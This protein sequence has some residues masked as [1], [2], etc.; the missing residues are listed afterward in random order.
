M[1]TSGTYNNGQ[2]ISEQKG[3]VLT[4]YHKDGKIKARGKYVDGLMQGKWIFNKKEGYLWN[5]GHFKDSKKHGKWIRY[6][7]DGSVEKEEMFEEGKR[8]K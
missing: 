7:S 6:K 5:V 4:Y 1:K 3:D 2:I 8:I